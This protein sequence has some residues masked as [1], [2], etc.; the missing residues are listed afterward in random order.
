MLQHTLDRVEAVIERE[1][2][3]TVI[4]AG[5]RPYLESACRAAIPGY[6]AEQPVARGTGPGVFLGATCVASV[7]PSATV[8]VFPSDHFL[9][10]EERFL[11]HVEH[12]VEL[13]ERL[14]DRLVLLGAVPR[15]PE[16]EY[17]WIEPGAVLAPG[18]EAEFRRVAGF[19]E[20]PNRLAA[21]RFHKLHWLSNT[22][23]VAAKVTT[24]WR[25]GE[26][27]FPAMMKQ[28]DTLRAALRSVRRRSPAEAGEL[29]ALRHAY[30]NIESANLSAGILERAPERSIVLPMRDVDWDDWG[31]PQRVVESLA[32]IG[33]SPS[34]PPALAGS[35]MPIEDDERRPD[36]VLSD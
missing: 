27:F 7:D 21:Q 24:L 22:M 32:R 11:A 8:V 14:D 5:H 3:I 16:P 25:L 23:I 33:R 29:A 20:K 10:P 2:I 17:G 18:S 12:V 19:F 13:V 6:V 15:E 4:G 34:F 31:R 30:R 1:R 26:R 35:E 36:Y 9:Y 28:F